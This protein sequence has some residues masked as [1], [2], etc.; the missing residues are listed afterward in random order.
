MVPVFKRSKRAFT[1]LELIVTLVIMA[2]LASIA[3]P[4]FVRVQNKAESET[5]RTEVAATLRNALAIN[6]GSTSALLTPD[7]TSRQLS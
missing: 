1:L 2:L 6:W 7:V 3:I 5:A 4:T